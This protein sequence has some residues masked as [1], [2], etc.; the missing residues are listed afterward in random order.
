[1][2]DLLTQAGESVSPWPPRIGLHGRYQ[3]G[4]SRVPVSPP[5]AVQPTQDQMDRD[6]QDSLAGMGGKLLSL[7]TPG[8]GARQLGSKMRP[9]GRNGDGLVDEASMESEP[10]LNEVGKM[11]NNLNEL[12]VKKK[13]SV[14]LSS[15]EGVN[16]R[17]GA[18]EGSV[19]ECHRELGSS[20]SATGNTPGIDV[21]GAASSAVFAGPVAPADLAGA[22]APAIAGTEFPVV[23]GDL[24]SADDAGGVSSAVPASELFRTVSATNPRGTA[25]MTSSTDWPGP[26]RTPDINSARPGTQDESW[27]Q[28]G[29]IQEL[30]VYP[31]TV[32][33]TN[34]T[35][36][37]QL[38][39]GS[40]ELSGRDED[41][42]CRIDSAVLAHEVYPEQA[43]SLQDS[44]EAIVVRAIGSAAPGWA[45]GI[46][47]EFMIDTG[48]Q[49]TILATTVFE[50]MC[51]SNP[52]VRSWLR[53][54]GRRLVSA[55]SSPLTVWGE[56][57]IT[58][59]SVIQ[60]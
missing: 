7:F 27:P 31:D 60:L 48:F 13:I 41:Q 29:A 17:Q 56:L 5:V 45:E 26:V 59:F 9:A 53:P 25:V 58:C 39:R 40:K 1:M 32:G 57:D 4:I 50:K 35:S 16:P 52:R 30:I 54:C 20:R 34:L 23:A 51:A 36:A 42:K 44:G 47:I 21:A 49:V 33:I 2:V 3:W 55:D 18:V 10:I 46:E 43:E 12:I 37:R 8:S 19:Q 24:S 15:G 22:V 28:A 11:D 38:N 14:T 6:A